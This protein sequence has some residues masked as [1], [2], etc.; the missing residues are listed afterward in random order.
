MPGITLAKHFY[1]NATN[2]LHYHLRTVLIRTLQVIDVDVD[3]TRNTNLFKV[4]MITLVSVSVVFIASDAG[5]FSP[6]SKT[7]R[8]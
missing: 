2:T 5:L 4:K 3:V 1:G 6:L 7:V 8:Q